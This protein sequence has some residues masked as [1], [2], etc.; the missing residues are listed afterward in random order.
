MTTLSPP[1]TTSPI[2]GKINLLFFRA[3]HHRLIRLITLVS[4]FVIFYELFLLFLSTK[5][6]FQIY[7]VDHSHFVKLTMKHE[8]LHK[9]L[10]LISAKHWGLFPLPTTRRCQNYGSVAPFGQKGAFLWFHWS[11]LKVM[12]WCHSGHSF[13]NHCELLCDIFALQARVDLAKGYRVKLGMIQF[14]SGPS[15]WDKV[16]R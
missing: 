3:C 5:Y 1:S 14:E 15:L 6:I 2:S 16:G 4:L 11:L 9:G 13:H 12:F 8:K 7:D 10:D